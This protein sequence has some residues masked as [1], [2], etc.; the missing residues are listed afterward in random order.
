MKIEYVY[1]ISFVSED[2]F[3]S[4]EIILDKKITKFEEVQN[5]CKELEEKGFENVTILNYQFLT[6][7]SEFYEF[8]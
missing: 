4:A 7:R 5:I 1:F 3:N 8:K 2:G 6:M